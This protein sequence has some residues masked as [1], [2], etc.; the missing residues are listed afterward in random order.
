M[1]ITGI[2]IAGGKSSRMG[3]NKALLE[4]AGQRFIDNAIGTIKPLCDELMVSSNVAIANLDYPVVSDCYDSIGP[5]GGLQSCL[6]QSLN[7]INALIPC[8]VPKVTISHY[9][10]L[11]SHLELNDAVIARHTDGKVEP[12]IAIYR[13]SILPMLEQQ[14]QLKDYKM[15]HLLKKLKV[16]YVD[17][18]NSDAF[19]NV[20]FPK[21][22]KHD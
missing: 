4:Y 12:L 2:V 15:M 14:I 8:D 1:Q 19:K 16:A 17:F 3:S 5:M 6:H 22:L 13:K 18:S 11:L 7:E 20:N 10:K 9:R 21:D